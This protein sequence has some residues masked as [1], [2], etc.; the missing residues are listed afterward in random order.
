MSRGVASAH[1]HGVAFPT[2]PNVRPF[3]YINNFKTIIFPR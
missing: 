1:E 2:F 3:L